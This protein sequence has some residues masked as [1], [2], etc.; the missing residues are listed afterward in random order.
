MYYFQVK[1]G[2][3]T[4]VGHGS[5]KKLAKRAAAE[6]MLEFMGVSLL[7][8][9]EGSSL[10]LNSLTKE[11]MENG[12]DEC[13]Q[14]MSVKSVGSSKKSVP[15]IL[16]LDTTNSKVNGEDETSSKNSYKSTKSDSKNLNNANHDL[17]FLE[18]AG[19]AKVKLQKLSEIFKFSVS[20]S[21]FQKRG[22]NS[23]SSSSEYLTLVSLSMKPAQGRETPIKDLLGLADE[24]FVT[25][26]VDELLVTELPAARWVSH[27]SGATPQ[28]SQ[29]DAAKSALKFLSENGIE[30]SSSPSSNE[31]GC[32]NINN[33]CS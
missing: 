17:D 11:K 3:L 7:S 10:K 2:D 19:E 26:L 5:N 12:S 15:G 25:D 13:K 9:E 23:S 33:N 27:G 22:K 32:T 8:K 31:N 24:L 20:Y 21:D 1:V 16:Y 28:E 4:A 14:E 6:N 18:D 29:E 30:V